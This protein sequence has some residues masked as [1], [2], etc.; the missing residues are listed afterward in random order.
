MHPYSDRVRVGVV[1]PGYIG[2]RHIEA[3]RHLDVTL[4]GYARS[5]SRHA[6]V[7]AAY[8]EVTWHP[9]VA[10]LL[11][12]VEVID[13]CTPTD[14]HAD[15]V[16][17]AASAGRQVVC[18]KPLARTLG[19]AD[20]MITACAAAGV[21]LFVAHLGRYA[22]GYAAA[23]QAVVDGE[24]GEPTELRL[25]R[26]GAAPGWASWFDDPARSGGVLL[27]LGIH[28]IDFARWIAGDVIDVTGAMT[29]PG[30][31]RA[32][33][34]HAGGARSA[35]TAEWGAAGL[36]F[37]TSFEIIGTAG[38]LTYDSVTDPAGLATD[39]MVE[40]L[41]EFRAAMRGGPPP[42]I[43]VADAQAALRVALAAADD[44]ADSAE[45]SG[46][47]ASAHRIGT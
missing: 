31:G 23:R 18:E 7:A 41:G 29:G 12:A 27:D 5:A 33:L 38:E 37:R 17:R 28:D 34:T 4:H 25:Y 16:L 32:I 44:A 14:A 45:G 24:V 15:V 42:R 9:S 26:G 11:A 19:E 22:A 46:Q 8:P 2:V 47:H 30:R 20:A 35:V 10:G 40:M 43:T 39:P 36:P 1:G 21:Q 3:W 13:V 6:E